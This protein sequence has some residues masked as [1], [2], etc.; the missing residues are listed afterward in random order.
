MKWTILV[1]NRHLVTYKTCVLVSSKEQIRGKACV[2]QSKPGLFIGPMYL[3]IG[4]MHLNFSVI[5]LN[6]DQAF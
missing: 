6:K 3:L 4:K 5:G 2:V 1:L